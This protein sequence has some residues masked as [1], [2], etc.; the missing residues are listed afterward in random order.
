M[1]IESSDN[2]SPKA[3]FLPQVRALAHY[4]PALES[5]DFH[6]GAITPGR[7]TES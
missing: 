6:A 4:L 2:I 5:P 7:K 3:D 1:M